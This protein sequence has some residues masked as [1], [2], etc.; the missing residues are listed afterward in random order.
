MKRDHLI[1]DFDGSI[2]CHF[3]KYIMKKL[4]FVILLSSLLLGL[5][6]L[7]IA[8]SSDYQVVFDITG[9]DPAAQ[10]QVVREAGLIKQAHPDASVE[11]VIYGQG[12]SLVQKDVS[13]QAEAVGK[14]I[15]Q[16]VS[17]K[18]C[19]M[20]MKRNNVDKD[21]LIS[22][23]EVVPDGIYELVS[24]QKEGWGYIKIAH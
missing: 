20:S 4:K 5:N 1:V 19:Q 2:H 7:A 17:F 15:S 3:K 11:I 14:L 8:Q 12:L 10:Q 16:K 21:Q 23:V 24:K 22:G 13:T 9:A 6:H 18:A